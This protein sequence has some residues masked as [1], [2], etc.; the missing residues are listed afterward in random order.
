MKSPRLG[1]VLIASASLAV[2]LASGSAHAL[3]RTYVSA[4]GSDTNACT[5]S[6]PCRLLPAAL[7][8]TDSG[9]EVWI[10]DSANYNIAPVIVTKSVTILAI[11]GAL[12]SVVGNGGNGFT[13]S[14]AGINVTIQNLTIRNL[15]AGDIGVH[16]INAATVSI[17]NCNIFGF[18]ATGG[19]G[20]WVN[21]GANS[22]RVNVVGSI[23]RNN[24]HGIIVAGNGH[25]TISGTHVLNNA[26]AGVNASSG[27]GIAIVHV[28][29]SVASGN[30]S[31]FVATGSA[32]AFNSYMYV[33]RSIA[34]ENSGP[35][36]SADGGITAYLVVGES[37][38]TNNGTGFNNATALPASFQSRGDNTVTGN[39]TNVS[40]SIASQ[41]GI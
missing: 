28:T 20:I 39:G 18:T 19:L 33:T 22:P 34:T 31:G 30:G 32:G 38:A 16:V 40:G 26:N 29:D 35:G 9:G 6:A 25:T 41:A 37:M 13:I 21:P 17:I 23:V 2:L 3:F 4:L 27:T 7:A 14:G 12:G 10:Q 15:S 24:F 5:V 36:F 1:R 11:P 8:A